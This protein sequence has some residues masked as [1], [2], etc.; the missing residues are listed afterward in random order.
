MRVGSLAPSELLAQRQLWIGQYRTPAREDG[1]AS[2]KPHGSVEGRL[3]PCRSEGDGQKDL[4]LHSQP[5]CGCSY[6]VGA[7]RSRWAPGAPCKAPRQVSPAA[8]SLEGDTHTQHRHPFS[9]LPAMVS[10]LLLHQALLRDALGC[11]LSQDIVQV[12]DVRVAVAGE[13]R[14][15]LCLVVD[16]IP[17]HR[18]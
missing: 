12:V 8:L 3:P 9:C 1:Q 7:T 6:W 2:M 4:L 15:K 16:L 18:V 10:V 11:K 14:A 13:V 17:D 5:A